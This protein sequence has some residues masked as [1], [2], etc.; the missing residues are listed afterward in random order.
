VDDVLLILLGIAWAIGTPVLAIAAL[1]RTSR[2]RTQ[3]ERLAADLAAI[4]RQMAEGAAL[5]PPF[6][7]PAAEIAP[8]FE[9]EP[10]LAE[11]M[12][13]PALA[14]AP[15]V[16]PVK[17]GWEQR[18]GA[19]A[20]LWIGAITLA[21][22]AVFLVRYSIEEGYLSPEVRVILAALFGFALIGGAEKVR[23]RDDRVA[24]ALAAAG[25]AALYGALF[26][27]VALYEMIS[28][29]AGGGGAAALTAFAIGLS[30]RHG[31]LV[32]TLAFVG[33]FVS[34]A[35]IG[36]DPPNTPVLFGY[37]LAIAAGTLSVI[38]VRGW[39]PLGW[40]VLAGSALWTLLW[41]L[42]LAG[43]LQWVG[44]F[45]VVVA[46]LF[47]W[48]T[49]RRLSEHENPPVDVAALVWAALGL[50]GSLLVAVIIQDEGKQSAGWL[51]LAAHGA[52]LYVL[53][54][55]TPRFQYVAALAPLLS[56]AALALWWGTTRVS[57]TGWDA[58]R[59]AWI[60]ILFGGFYAGG[61]FALLWNAGRPGFWAA[62]SVS[63]ALVHFLLC[64][65][66]L[67]SVATTTPWG[68]ISIGLAVPFLVGAE[69]L[70]RW[71]GTMTGATEALGFLAAGVVFFIAAAIPLELSREWITVAYAIEFAAVAAIA[72]RLDLLAMRQLCWPLLAVVVVRLVLNPEILK[73]PLGVTP[74]LNW[75]L[76]AYGI[77]IAA[78]MVG[79]RFLRP[80]GDERLV[81]ATEAAVALL[82][83]VLAT[84]EVRSVFQPG[85]MAA[86]DAGFL[87]RTFYVLVWGGFALAGLWLARTRR[88]PVALWA[89]RASGALALA[90]VLVVQVLIANPVV[91][92]VDIG[93][94]PIAN[95][96]FLAYA[97]PAAMAALA[98]RWIDVEP[99][100][101]VALLVEAAASILAFVYVSLEVR[102]LFD[103]GFERPGFGASG[104][105]LY[106]Y[107]IVWL[108][109]GVALLAVGF[110]R[111]AAALR[112]AGMAL[113]CV[114]VAKVF[115]IDMAGLQGL[116]R[117]FS[118][119]GLGA[120]LV[121]L[122][123]AY[124]RFGFDEGQRTPP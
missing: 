109:F 14:P 38:R 57:G 97:V 123:Y 114:V 36:S 55:W 106:T 103:P 95:G 31:M 52:G 22:A 78:L 59:F 18:L 91:E 2:L 49:W 118:F 98:R 124:R 104:L 21:L 65:Y 54:R 84:L 111:G 76:W 29:V 44:L 63:A 117:V 8:P 35:I 99:N 27:A 56:I 1:V 110:L 70:V 58:D 102:H 101:N 6:E 68:L 75:I 81:R 94:L 48:A 20:F 26:A 62:L 64:W 24:Q 45:L 74:I 83:F 87:E 39:W 12:P 73:Y 41:M 30:L 93:R 51:A 61:A 7:A 53:A 40:G 100:R 4:R 66:V 43:G 3:N 82:I 85:S 107:S 15:V 10:T 96:L 34:P 50:T 17:A 80:T 19:R 25:V 108:L 9:P 121:G 90:T 71:R 11:I 33:G 16:E 60:T 77:S 23:P 92:K 46:G 116:L 37:L 28:K 119:L 115:L 86:A 79:L 69:R 113:V 67:R 72:A 89:W 88:D 122:G 105:E 47:V 13:L 5:P 112:H 120:A 32:A 42:S